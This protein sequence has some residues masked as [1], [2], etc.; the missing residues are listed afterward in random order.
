[1]ATLSGR[2]EASEQIVDRRYVL[3]DQLGQGA[4]GNVFRAI[5]RLTGHEVALKLLRADGGQQPTRDSFVGLRQPRLALAIEFQTLSSLHHPNVIRVRDYGFDEPGGPYFTMDLLDKPRSITEEARGKTIQ[6]KIALL[7]QL[8]RALHYVHRRGIVHR[9][10]KPSNILCVRGS[11]RVTDFGLAI[12]VGDGTVVAGTPAFIAPELWLGGTP[13]VASDLYSVG[14]IAHEVIFEREPTPRRPGVLRNAA[15][16]PLEGPLAEFVSNLLASDP[17][18]RPRGALDVLYALGEATG[19]ALAVETAATRESF[20]QASAFVGRDE[21]LARLV[22]ALEEARARRGGGWLVA[23]ESGIGK[24]RLTAE[25]RTRALV[26]GAYVVTGQATADGGALFEPWLPVLRALC[27]RVNLSDDEAA[28]IRELLP[29]VAASIG[30]PVPPASSVHPSAIQARLRSTIESL[31]SRQ[32]QATVVL[33]EDLQW[34][35]PDSLALVGHLA[36][37]ARSLPLLILGTYR[38]DE[39]PH[40]ADQLTVMSLLKLSRM[41]REAVTQLAVSMLGSRGSAPEV[42]DYLCRETEG[43]VFFLVEVVRALAEQTGQL[44]RIAD[45][46]LPEGLLTGG[47]ERI[48]Y[49][50]IDRLPA[51]HRG[52]LELAA[53]LGRDVD[54]AVLHCLEPR[55]PLDRWLGTCAN[56]AVLE[57]RGDVFRFAHDKLREAILVHIAPEARRSMHRRV[58]AALE[59]VYAGPQLDAKSAHVAHHFR[60]AGERDKAAGFS[61]RAGDRATRLCSYGEARI[62]YG[63][64]MEAIEGLVASTDTNRLKVDVLLKQIY[65]TL[66]VQAAEKNFKYAA[67][68]RVLLDAAIRES[69]PS[70]ED[71]ERLAR[72]NYFSC[73]IGAALLID[74]NAIDAEP[75]LAPAI[76]PLDGLGDPFEWSRA[77][78][79]HGLSLVALGRY[80]AGVAELDRIRARAR[81]IGQPSLLSAAYLMTGSTFLFSGDWPLAIDNLERTLEYAAETGDKVHL[82]FAWSG[83]GWAYSHLAE[84]ARAES[85]QNEAQR[86]ADTLGGR[87]MLNDWYR[88]GDAEIALLA[89]NADVAVDRARAIVEAEGVTGQL[90]SRGVAERVW[91]EA[92]AIAGDAA[93]T[94]AHMER[95]IALHDS[96]GIHVQATRTRFRWALRCRARGDMAR[97]SELWLAAHQQF[98]SYGCA[99]AVAECERLWREAGVSG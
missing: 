87:L 94:D 37:F 64:A 8:L 4:I 31:F 62:H 44:D 80:D 20:L 21:E 72:L 16:P 36:E 70:D 50:R 71:E 60:A 83:L 77:V 24:S 85:C 22:G 45:S 42:I 92:V 81:E 35:S 40:L 75:L 99:Y 13:S 1:M 47:I 93:A 68:A 19:T 39:A 30:R 74:G 43:S 6:E 58:A 95:S 69:G 15:D 3:L 11:V 28:V 55:L 67:R 9:D 96:G 33:L 29:E 79:Y 25:L 46:D 76:A 7:T 91:A 5:D 88:A 49:R 2:I 59:Q 89:G 34:A 48:A 78:G 26:A 27:L 90:F 17:M 53:V 41:D 82:S 86:I 12:S 10:L 51:S 57:S 73:L 56:A 52:P 38:D 54:A 66:G 23:G 84:H 61:I 63:A 65:T 14:V 32:P 18:Q 97:A 98:S